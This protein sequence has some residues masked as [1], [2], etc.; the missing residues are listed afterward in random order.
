[1]HGRG[2]FAFLGE[3]FV[4]VCTM[5]ATMMGI[6]PNASPQPSPPGSPRGTSHRFDNVE[7]TLQ[8]TIQQVNKLHVE[9]GILASKQ[10]DIATEITN[11]V[12]LQFVQE[13]TNV[14]EIVTQ[15]S[16][17]FERLREQNVQQQTGLQQLFQSTQTEIN[18]MKQKMAELE[19]RSTGD[20]RSGPTENKR[21]GMVLMK[22]LKPATFNGK[23]EKW[24]AWVE[25]V[26]DYVEANHRG[27]RQVLEKVEKLKNQEADEYWVMNQKD[28]NGDNISAEII[29][30]LF[31]VLKMYT[32]PGTHARDIVM[33]TQ[34][35]SG[36]MAWQRLFAHY[37]PELA[38][39]EGQALSNVLM[40]QT[41][42]AKNQAELRGLV[43]EL[44]GKV[45]VCK[46]LCGI[47]VEENIL[48]SVLAGML[49]AETRLHTTRYHGMDTPY[50]TLRIEVL[51][52]INATSMD[53]DAMNIGRVGEAQEGGGR[54]A[55]ADQ[56]WPGWNGAEDAYDQ[57]LNAIKGGKAKGK[58]KGCF[59]CG[60]PEHWARECPNP[61]TG[62]GGQG[63]KGW[64]G[65][66][67]DGGKGGPGKGFGKGSGK[68]GPKGGCWNCGGNHYASDC[69][70][71]GHSKGKGKGKLNGMEEYGEQSEGDVGGDGWSTP[72]VN[73]WSTPSVRRLSA[74]TTVSPTSPPK[75]SLGYFAALAEEDEQH[76]HQTDLEQLN[77]PATA[78]N[79]A[80]LMV[81]AK[82][83]EKQGERKKKRKIFSQAYNKAAA[84]AECCGCEGGDFTAKRCAK[85]ES[86]KENIKGLP[87]DVKQE[88]RAL[89]TVET[90]NLNSVQ[91]EWQE[92]EFTVD[93]GASETVMAEDELPAVKTKEGAAY[94]RGVE[95]EVANGTRIANEG[96]K[97][98]NAHTLTGTIRTI[99][100]Q[101][102]DV[103]KPLLSVRKIV[104]SGNRVVFEPNGAFIEDCHTK[105]KL[106]LDVNGGMYTLKVWIK[107]GDKSGF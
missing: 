35:K 46:D 8:E 44:E 105:E 31:T 25:E 40:M 30:E 96:E 68:G 33:N 1:M 79:M 7:R 29:E 92:V 71:N 22:D 99:T 78:I 12:Q 77:P 67:G 52:F 61:P 18:Q 39:R 59:N 3:T 95:Y 11:Q 16:S 83:K 89:S 91:Q 102:C 20:A 19:Q 15:A 69:P 94:K 13:R 88:L 23:P 60:S 24:R 107:G 62:K 58:G 76:P 45:R 97:T 43:V 2:A 38:A 28:A 6:T 10:T 56:E 26:A 37:Q 14:Q 21:K 70:Q 55:P 74:M 4:S 41:R 90:G 72:S 42:R 48:R 80:D 17:E 9:M 36:F 57:Y 103:N 34:K 104:E 85:E 98:F 27:L 50:E 49:D 86:H 32:E 75:V 100:A 54:E 106:K 53:N 73:G 51:K 65:G 64:K 87:G 66:K 101:I 47:D 81:N 82:V 93:S 84:G 5:A 63:G